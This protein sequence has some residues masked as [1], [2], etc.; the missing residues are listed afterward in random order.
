M[1]SRCYSCAG[2]GHYYKAHI[3]SVLIKKT[4]KYLK[5]KKMLYIIL[6]GILIV[7]FNLISKI[8]SDDGNENKKNIVE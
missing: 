7:V 1:Q 5:R 6:I 8:N 2:A 3:A 4:E